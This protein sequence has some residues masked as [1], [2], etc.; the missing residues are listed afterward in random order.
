MQRAKQRPDT[1]ADIAW[2]IHS[3]EVAERVNEERRERYP[4]LTPENV[5]E[6]MEWQAARIAELMRELEREYRKGRS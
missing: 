3:R 4:V 1:A 6:A 5:H 2:R